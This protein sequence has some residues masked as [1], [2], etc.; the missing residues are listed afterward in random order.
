MARYRIGVN[1][2]KMREQHPVFHRRPDPK[3]PLW[4]YLNFPKFVSLLETG[5]L[6]FSRADLMDDPLEGSF[7]KSRELARQGALDNPPKGRTRETQEA[8][9]QHNQY[10]TQE[11]RKAIY[12]SCWHMGRH[13]SMAMW[14]GYGD[15]AYGVAIQTDYE[16]LDTILPEEK[17]PRFAPK[18]KNPIYVGIVRYIDLSSPTACIENDN[19]V[20]A[21]FLYKSVLYEHEQEVRGI[22]WLPVGSPKGQEVSGHLVPAD[23]ALLVK[24]VTISPLAPPWFRDVVQSLCVQFGFSFPVG[25]SAASSNPIF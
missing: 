8:I 20:F 10:V 24:S 1:F 15:G 19:N 3:T 4:R 11:Y 17:E 23:L 14:R 2:C 9:F 22:F 16:T 18:I 6:Y 7:P 5:S 25:V 13:E 21:P 12:V